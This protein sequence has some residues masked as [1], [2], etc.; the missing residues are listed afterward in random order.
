MQITSSNTFHSKSSQRFGVPSPPSK[1][2]KQRGRQ[3]VTRNA[4]HF[5]GELSRPVLISSKAVY[6]LALVLHPYY[7]L[8]YIKMPWGGPEEQEQERAPGNPHAKDWYDEALKVVEKMMADYWRERPGRNNPAPLVRVPNTASASSTK[9][10]GAV[11]SDFDRHRRLLIEQATR[12]QDTGWA[13]ELRR[14]LQDMP[15]DVTKDTDII[16]WWS[17]HAAIYP[18]LA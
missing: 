18:T 6:I 13:A 16:K 10:S 2:C 8:A 3:S 1:S 5:T 14:Y 17:K 12:N 11:E 9:K 4:M 7:K 15:E